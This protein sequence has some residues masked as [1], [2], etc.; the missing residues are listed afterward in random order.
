MQYNSSPTKREPLSE[1][2]NNL[3]HK[4]EE[5]TTSMSDSPFLKCTD[6]LL[7]GENSYDMNMKILPQSNSHTPLLSADSRNDIDNDNENEE[8]LITDLNV[9]DTVET[10]HNKQQQNSSLQKNHEDTTNLKDQIQ[11]DSN[12]LTDNDPE[13]DSE[14][15]ESTESLVKKTPETQYELLMAYREEYDN[16]ETEPKEGL[17]FYYINNEWLKL[18]LDYDFDPNDHQIFEK[19]GK[20][21]TVDSDLESPPIDDSFISCDKMFLL[22]QWFQI[23]SNQNIIKREM[24]Y[25]K[26][27]HKFILD[28]NP[29]IIIPHIFVSNA[30]HVNRYNFDN[31]TPEIMIPAFK[32]LHHLLNSMCDYFEIN[33]L[34]FKV[35]RLWKIEFDVTNTSSIIVPHNLKHITKKKLLSKRKKRKHTTLKELNLQYAHILLEIK[36]NDNTYYLD[37]ENH[38]LPGSGLVGLS[39]L[40]NTCYMNSALQCLAHIPELNYYFLYRFFDKELNKD[41]PLGNGG[42]VAMAF[43]GLISALFDNRFSGNQSSY[44]PREFKYT[45][46]HFNSLFADY[47]QQDSQEF[48]AYLLD[49]LHEDLNR[50]L[51]KPYVNKPELEEGKENDLEAIKILAE[52]CWDCHKLRNNSVIVDLFVALYKS[53]LLCPICNHISITFD[54][55]NDLTLPLPITKKWLHK[56]NIF[57]DEG[58]P[59]SLEIELN[60]SASYSDLKKSISK[61]TNIPECELLGIEILKSNIYKNFEDPSSDSRYLP[62]SELIDNG[63]DIW[64]YQIKKASV[65]DSIF[66]VFSTCV[67]NNSSYN[68]GLPFFITLSE[69]DMRTY[70]KIQQKLVAKYHQLSTSSIFNPYDTKRHVTDFPD[71]DIFMDYFRINGEVVQYSENDI[72]EYANPDISYEYY[73]SIK[74][75]DSSMDR[76]YRNKY[77]Y[78]YSNNSGETEFGPMI[79]YP[80]NNMT[81]LSSDARAIFQ[82]VS[83]KDKAFYIY[84]PEHLK[85]LKD[86][87]DS[88]AAKELEENLKDVEIENDD[89]K[90]NDDLEKMPEVLES[91]DNSDGI[92]ENKELDSNISLDV[93]TE[94]INKQENEE[95]Y[96]TATENGSENNL[97]SA[98]DKTTENNIISSE[99]RSTTSSSNLTPSSE[100]NELSDNRSSPSIPSNVGVE[101]LSSLSSSS[102]EEMEISNFTQYINP[103]DA[104]VCEFSEKPFMMCFKGDD[105]N[106]E[107]CGIATWQNPEVI[108]NEEVENTRKENEMNAKKAVTL[109]D[110]LEI[111]SKP[112]VLGQNDLWYCPNC[113]EHRQATKKIELWSAPDI[114]TIHLKRFESTRSFSDKI[115]MVID[116]PIEELDL[117]KYVADKDGDHIYDLFAVDNH[118]GGLGGGHYTAYAKNFVDSKWYYF[119]DSRVSKVDDPRDAIRGNA[120]LLF[121]RKRSTKPLGGDFFEKIYIEIDKQRNEL[122]KTLQESKN[123]DLTTDE[124]MV[125]N[126][127]ICDEEHAMKNSNDQNTEDADLEDSNKRRKLEHAKNSDPEDD[128]A[129]VSMKITESVE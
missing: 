91:I 5:K 80:E 120:Y 66:P 19:I 20:V 9:N 86:L 119:D 1:T 89:E 97:I 10:E 2:D 74:T 88:K 34:N 114:L 56:V 106:D 30:S 79:W 3:L 125:E 108:R 24:V 102:D 128:S 81:V 18:F 42:K 95:A 103:K 113:K 43:G 60:K 39:N 68:F 96:F 16:T 28:L 111:F 12:N 121:Y 112:E 14:N 41:N 59:K 8:Q 99:S 107:M 26:K 67:S 58:Y 70:G 63:D 104:I 54:P 35:A 117:S 94:D 83:S 57:P 126:D 72:I 92:F 127:E 100:S 101:Q 90:E 46:G 118:Y 31:T 65:S 76:T 22:S 73:F 11:N 44:S 61:L 115:D 4:I 25:C 15:T 53:T 21:K 52:K 124:E 82:K 71:I 23:A 105:D 78:S 6:P 84:S 77:N 49:G 109:Y 116:F 50:V 93:A 27:E 38:V 123:I 45:I 7:N 129:D 37:T 122:E 29:I 75:I 33:Q 36:Q 48:I 64:F 40:G 69:S 51:K 32:N 47:H 17:S 55:Y 110:C 87:K 62:I 98:K 13:A 85:Y